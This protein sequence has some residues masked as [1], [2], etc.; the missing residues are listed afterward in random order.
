MLDEASL[1]GGA[2]EWFDK[3]REDI[4]A[5]VGYKKI[6]ELLKT[7]SSDQ[8]QII[9]ENLKGK[10]DKHQLLDIMEELR[11][12]VKY[13]DDKPEFVQRK[14]NCSTPDIFLRKTKEY[15]E[16]KRINISDH[17]KDARKEIESVGMVGESEPPIKLTA[18]VR[19]RCTQALK[20]KIEHQIN[21]GREQL[22][23]KVGF[24][25]MSYSIDFLDLPYSTGRSLECFREDL[26]QECEEYVR[27][28]SN[29]N[30]V[31]VVCEKY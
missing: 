6:D 25:Y 16:V 21:K 15:I 2:K 20:R 3:C 11:V 8:I 9:K 4:K 27:E 24:M 28:Y 22:S 7:L 13:K 18:D 5:D 31:R 30:G 19:E 26:S 10:N 1:G 23:G 14:A 17:E 12:G 29:E